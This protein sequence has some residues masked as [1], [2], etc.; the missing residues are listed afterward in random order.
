MPALLGIYGT[1]GC[2]RGIMPFARVGFSTAYGE[3][4]RAVFIDDRPSQGRVNGHNI[5]SLD[6]FLRLPA[7]ERFVCVAVADP[8]TRQGI[9]A[10]CEGA[11]LRAWT[12]VA[13]SVVRMDNVDLGAGAAISPFKAPGARRA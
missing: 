2:G 4:S 3:G 9:W 1:G 5:V 8:R 13:D 6:E 11:G 12:A 7:S 10:R